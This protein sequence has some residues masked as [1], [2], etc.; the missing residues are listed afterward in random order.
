[1]SGKTKKPSAA[2]MIARISAILSGRASSRYPMEEIKKNNPDKKM[3]EGGKLVGGQSKLDKN[4]NGKIDG[5]D[6]KMMNKK[7]YGGKAKKPVKKMYGGTAK[8]PVKKMMGGM[9]K[10]KKMMGGGM[11][12][13]KKMMGGGK[14]HMKKKK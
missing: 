2:Q 3:R 9:A 11:M 12:M 14:A 6:F 8:K 13:K 7:A 1:M 5:E 4:K 10:K